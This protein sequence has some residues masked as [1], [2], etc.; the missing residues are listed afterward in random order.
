VVIQRRRSPRGVF[1]VRRRAGKGTGGRQV[2]WLLRRETAALELG[3]AEWL[4]E[5]KPRRSPGVH[6]NVSHQLGTDGWGPTERW[7]QTDAPFQLTAKCPPWAARLV[8]DCDGR[9]T[10]REHLEA[11]RESGV[12][13]EQT[14]QEVLLSS[15]GVLLAGGF[16][17]VEGLEPPSPTTSPA[18]TSPGTR[19]SAGA[20]ASGAGVPR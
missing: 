12:I 19:G 8:A 6:L 20:P 7:L 14:S 10:V 15:V 18:R 9:I 5:A 17:H 13:G 4:L 3:S 11:L 1:S 2:D 16:I